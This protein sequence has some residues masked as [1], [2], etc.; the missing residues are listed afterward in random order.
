MDGT[1]IHTS[2]GPAALAMAIYRNPPPPKDNTTT[3]VRAG[4]TMA[5]AKGECKVRGSLGCI[6]SMRVCKQSRRGQV[7][8][9]EDND[10]REKE[11]E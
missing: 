10:M 4:G 7:Q 11:R 5:L 1:Y 9:G 8:R 2:C 3:V 6:V